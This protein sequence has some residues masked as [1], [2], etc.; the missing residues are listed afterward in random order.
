MS[1][2]VIRNFNRIQLGQNSYRNFLVNI[3]VGYSNFI[4]KQNRVESLLMAGTFTSPSTR[5]ILPNNSTA[6]L[7]TQSSNSLIHQNPVKELLDSSKQNPVNPDSVDNWMTLSSEDV[8]EVPEISKTHSLG[9]L[10][11][12]NS[13]GINVR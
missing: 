4:V 12:S 1:A 8:T 6:E 5:A 7:I 3:Q 2:V 9:R 11:A 10:Q 13:S